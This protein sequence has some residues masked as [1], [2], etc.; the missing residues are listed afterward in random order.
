MLSIL[1]PTYNYNV[2]PLVENLYNQCVICKIPF[3]IIV[4]DDAS[5]HHFDNDKINSLKNCSFKV[6]GKNI[7]RSAIRDLL[8]KTAKYDW[9]L[10]LDADVLPENKFFIQKYLNEMQINSYQIIVGGYRYED[11][12]PNE[13]QILRWKYGKDREYALAE[14]RNTKPYHY[15]FSGNILLQKSIFVEA[16]YSG[17]ENLYGMDI[18]FSYKIFENK[19][20]ILHIDNFI[21]H[22]GLENNQQFF[23]KSLKAVESRMYLY[24]KYPDVLA[25]SPLLQHYLKL[26]KY[27]S[28][29]L[30]K[31]WF[32]TFE[33]LLKKQ[34][35]SANP[36]LFLFDIYRLGYLC[37]L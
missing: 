32:K 33:P 24:N 11:Q 37:S 16:N 10:F 4:F 14:I 8:A 7:G 17:E 21:F 31:F 25:V 28:A 15:I 3:E 20:R 30:F 23:N 19:Y 12:K 34:L 29:S 26:K 13:D 18:Y 36:N 27:G 22:L 9:L 6:L 1:I 2:F 35:L 5:Q